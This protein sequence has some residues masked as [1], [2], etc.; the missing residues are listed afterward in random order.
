MKNQ[1]QPG[2]REVCG[3]AGQTTIGLDI[4]DRFTHFC[5]LDAEGSVVGE[6]RFRS[7]PDALKE[8][9]EG[10]PMCR[11]VLEVGTHSRWMSSILEELGH[12]VIVAN[13]RKVRLIKESDNKTDKMD[14]RTLARLAR[15]DP[16]LLAPITHRSRKIYPDLA[17][18]RARDLL[19]RSRTK[20]INAVRGIVKATGARLPECSTTAFAEKMIDELP[21][22]LRESLEPLIETI[23]H[24]SK[25]IATYDK[26]L[27]A[28]AKHEYPETI[29][30]RQVPGVGTITALH[31][32]LTIEDPT[33]FAKSRQ[34]GSFLGLQPRQSQSGDRAPQLGISK[35][36]DSELRCMLVQCAHHILG[37]F[38]KDCDLRRWGLS[39]MQRGGKNAKKRAIV[40]VARKL[41]VLLHRLWTT[42]APYDPF[43][44]QTAVA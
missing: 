3:S 9:F 23:R 26:Q 37:C 4:G 7:T 43:H 44:K 24:L 25:Q 14:A 13:A 5:I 19:V 38:G 22:E 1:Q 20:L 16:A 15:V 40:A 8:Q 12:E 34:V 35:A 33:R 17:K 28:I 2:L 10:V 32:V 41:A 11:V 30:L 18:L 31:F 36:G 6:G 42:D 27:E 39:L 21:K 29:K